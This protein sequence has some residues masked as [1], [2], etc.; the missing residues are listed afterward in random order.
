[1]FLRRYLLIIIYTFNIFKFIENYLHLHKKFS[2]VILYVSKIKI[3]SS[4]NQS[5]TYYIVAYI[6]IP[7]LSFYVIVSK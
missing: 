3:F 2:L 7:K 4:K 5:T 1:M 6:R